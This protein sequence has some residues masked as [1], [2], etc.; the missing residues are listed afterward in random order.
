MPRTGESDVKK[1]FHFLPA[2]DSVGLFDFR[3]A[4]LLVQGGDDLVASR[5]ADER[6]ITRRES[7]DA[8]TEERDNDRIPF[9][10][11]RFLRGD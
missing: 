6:R 5:H 3:L 10:A 11:F 9:R 8:P 1:A 7:Y 2:Q 4:I